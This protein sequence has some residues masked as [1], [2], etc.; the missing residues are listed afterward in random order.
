[1]MVDVQLPDGR[2]QPM[3]T[4]VNDTGASTYLGDVP[5]NELARM[6][7]GAE[8]TSGTCKDYLDQ[9]RQQLRAMGIHDDAVDNLWERVRRHS[10]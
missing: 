1:M 3:L 10:G 8:G 5:P 4:A 6:I 2:S 7:A 9:L